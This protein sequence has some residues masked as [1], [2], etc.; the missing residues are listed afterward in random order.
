V[1]SGADGGTARPTLMWEVR[2]APGRLAELLAWVEQQL[3]GR[4]ADGG[5]ADLYTAAD[6]RIVVILRAGP[7]AGSGPVPRL[8]EPPA[9]LLSRAVHQWPFTYLGHRPAAGQGTFQGT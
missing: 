2:A 3:A 1:V 6:D 5:S 4:P 9:E 8:P 7:E